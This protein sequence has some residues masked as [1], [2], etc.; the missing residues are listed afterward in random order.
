MKFFSVAVA[1]FV[2]SFAVVGMVASA[3]ET[4]ARLLSHTPGKAAVGIGI[5][6]LAARIANAM[7]NAGPKRR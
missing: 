3:N 2:V 5:L 6:I 1:V 4:V 7:D